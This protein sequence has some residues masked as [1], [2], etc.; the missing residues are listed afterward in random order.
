MKKPHLPEIFAHNK[1]LSF[2]V[3]TCFLEL[4][5]QL[6]KLFFG[7]LDVCYVI[8]LIPVAQIMIRWDMS[9]TCLTKWIAIL[10][11]RHIYHIAGQTNKF[12]DCS[13]RNNL[14]HCRQM[15]YWGAL[16][17][18]LLFHRFHHSCLE[19]SQQNQPKQSLHFNQNSSKIENMGVNTSSLVN[20]CVPLLHLAENLS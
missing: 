8:T 5:R 12:D 6:Y 2:A 19:I 20:F 13:K 11:A 16:G 18:K 14:S 9:R 17:V 1:C 15:R 10:L 7:W 4:L 3:H